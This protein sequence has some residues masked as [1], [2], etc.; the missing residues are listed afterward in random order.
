MAL[1]AR[2]P[3]KLTPHRIT[4]I[5]VSLAFILAKGI[6]AYHRLTSI[7]ITLDVVFGLLSLEYVELLHYLHAGDLTVT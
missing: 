2:L 5:I 7:S 3:V 4:V 1:F 6:T